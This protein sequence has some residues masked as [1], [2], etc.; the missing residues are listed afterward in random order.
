[1]IEDPDVELCR[2]LEVALG[3]LVLFSLV[4][5]GEKGGWGGIEGMLSEK[6]LSS[7]FK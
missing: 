1:M 3:L 5:G 7:L 2:I 6:K 4:Q